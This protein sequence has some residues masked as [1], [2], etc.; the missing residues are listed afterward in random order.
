ML[1]ITAKSHPAR[2]AVVMSG[3]IALLAMT[4]AVVAVAI[5]PRENYVSPTRAAAPPPGE[6]DSIGQS[7]APSSVD[8][9]TDPDVDADL[10]DA[11]V[12]STLTNLL[13]ATAG[14][15]S[16]P[17][18]DLSD[19][20]NFGSGAI[21]AELK[22][23]TTELQANGWTREGT[24]TVISLRIVRADSASGLVEACIDSSSVY[25]VDADGKRLPRDESTLR[26][27]NLFTLA[28]NGSDWR[29]SDRTFPPD[30]AC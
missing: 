10:D 14:V 27:F 28:H 24:P 23:D 2:I 21:L 15:A 30:A 29:I 4:I 18:M 6:S 7:P 1:R 8:T 9:D 13:D 12:E 5:S 26:S 20:E 11:I 25:T 22:A 19:V 3:L 16:N 17:T